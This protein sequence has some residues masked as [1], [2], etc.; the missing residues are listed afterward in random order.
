MPASVLKRPDV[1][2]HLQRVALAAGA[3]WFVA[4]FAILV[5]VW[6]GPGHQTFQS[7]DEAAN[8][9]GIVEVAD[10]LRPTTPAIVAD[11]VEFA[12]QRMWVRVDDTHVPAAAPGIMAFYGPI[13]ALPFGGWAL[14]LVPA[15]G[16]AALAASGVLIRESIVG[17]MLPGLAFPATYWML[18]PW[19]NVGLE[20]ALVALGVLAAALDTRRRS[21][22]DT[23]G[24]RFAPGLV[25]TSAVFASLVRPDHVHI[26]FGCS[27]AWWLARDRRIV[28]AVLV[29]LVAGGVWLAGTLGL[30]VWTTGDA[31]VPATGLLD[32]PTET[33]AFG[34]DL[35]FPLAEI[36]LIVAP[37]GVPPAGNVVT[38]LAK[39]WL[40][41]GP[42]AVLVIAVVV[43]GILFSRRH[44]RGGVAPVAAVAGLLVLHV[45]TRVSDSDFGA[46]SSV[47]QLVHSHPR[48]T[49]IAYLGLAVGALLLGRVLDRHDARDGLR[50]AAD[51]ALALAAVVGIVYLFLP[52]APGEGLGWLRS[53]LS[54]ANAYA[55]AVDAQVP[56][57]AVVYSLGVDKYLWA[58]RDVGIVRRERVVAGSPRIDE[59]RL[60]TSLR[61]LVRDTERPAIL[62]QLTPDEAAR[63]AAGLDDVA[64]VTDA[65]LTLP[66]VE[67][68]DTVAPSYL[69]IRC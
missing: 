62:L 44:A 57:D 36:L 13:G 9:R 33:V 58:V 14:F 68:I 31:L 18:R 23:A 46:T 54:D 27:L 66:P 1:A 24:L 51:G 34:Q 41:F 30:N 17:A 60:T 55:G 16:I 22:G 21:W 19:H 26:I 3:A 43:A 20:V 39:Y 10:H 25:L 11:D 32:F 35:G 56:E 49:A 29:H 63:V 45:L 4:A 48:Y 5:A 65:G 67:G 37:N 52:Q 15:L 28:R 7:P 42:V 12:H 69:V 47:P 59:Q 2:V 6:G 40:R 50:W 61:A 53:H 38:Q 64:C 8:A